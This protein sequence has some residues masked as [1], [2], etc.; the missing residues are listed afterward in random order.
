MSAN[1]E[2]SAVATGMEKVSF[3]PI[4]K[5]GN[6]KECSNYYTVAFISQDN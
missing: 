6:A 2:Y 1:S 4:S 5:K 3:H